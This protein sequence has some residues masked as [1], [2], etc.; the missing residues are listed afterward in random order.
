M[1]QEGRHIGK[2]DVAM[3]QATKSLE[4]KWARDLSQMVKLRLNLLVVFSAVFGALIAGAINSFSWLNL[5]FLALGGFLTTGAS[6]IFNQ[7]L[8]KSYDAQM[9]RTEDRPLPADR[10]SRNKA[11][12]I[13]GIFSIVG[14]SLLAS[15]NAISAIIGVLALI[16]YAFLY[17]PLKRITPFAVHVGAFPGALPVVIGVV[18]VTGSITPLAILLFTIQFFWQFA[19]FWAIAW[20][21]HDDYT[22]AGFKLL[23]S[24]ENQKTKE[25]GFHTILYTAVLIPASVML[26]VIPE[27]GV[28]T[29]VLVLIT[30]LIYLYQA[31]VFYRVGDDKTARRLMFGSFIYL[32]IVLIVMF[33]GLML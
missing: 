23:P 27:M 13:A 21:A 15:I 3:D 14:V 24:K 6:N 33:I 19:H 25:V 18:S 30:S 11:V 7:I 31:I 17:T 8:E 1:N 10:I 4:F 28:I 29:M 2:T 32:P 16:S 26:L 22:V 5:L 12:I 9:K 20:L